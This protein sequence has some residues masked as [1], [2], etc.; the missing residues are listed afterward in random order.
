MLVVGRDFPNRDLPNRDLRE[1]CD[2]VVNL[3][4]RICSVGIRERSDIEKKPTTR[5]KIAK[6]LVKSADRSFFSEVR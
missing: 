1:K 6:N 4:G 5:R 2:P 3:R